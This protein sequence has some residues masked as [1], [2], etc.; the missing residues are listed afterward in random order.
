VSNVVDLPESCWLLLA[1]EKRVAHV[2]PLSEVRD[3]IERTL[4]MNEA[5]RLDRKWIKR[6][7]EK[8]FV[9]FF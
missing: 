7:R 4:R 5:R 6:L 2:R 1:E 9:L 3:E 8:A